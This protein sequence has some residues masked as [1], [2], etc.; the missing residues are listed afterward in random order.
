TQPRGPPR[1]QVALGN[2]LVPESV[3][4]NRPPPRMVRRN[5]GPLRGNHEARGPR[6]AKQSFE[7]KYVTKCNLVTR[8]ACMTMSARIV[9]E[10]P[11]RSDP[12]LIGKTAATASA[13]PAS[14]AAAATRRRRLH[15]PRPR[16]L[17]TRDAL[18]SCRDRAG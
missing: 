16:R 3:L 1:Y 9:R 10:P 8:S 7:Y 14:H 15:R 6:R 2:E 18:W 11:F 12:A 5:R 17:P 13:P 4:R